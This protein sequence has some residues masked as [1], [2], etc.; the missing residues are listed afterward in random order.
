MFR[1]R[2]DSAYDNNR[3]DRA[4]YFYAQCGCNGPGLPGPP[5]LERSVDYQDF[6]SYLE[7]AANE[8]FSV[9]VE[10]PWRL[11]N[12]EVNA[13]TAGYAD[14]NAGF[15]VGLIAVPTEQYLTFQLRAYFPTGD[16]DRGLGTDHYTLEPAF[17]F[18]SRFGRAI[19]EGEFKDWI[20]IGGTDFAGNVL[21]Y[22][23]GLSYVVLG[24][25]GVTATP[26]GQTG[27]W[28]APVLEFVGWTVLDG[29]QTDGQTGA[30]LDASGDTIVNV[31]AGV[32]VGVGDYNSIYV[33]Y[34]R[35]LT[36][37]VWYRDLVRVEYRLAF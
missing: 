2:Y 6:R 36:G 30:I 13:N 9:F 28:A 16:A 22:G 4:E 35:A 18:F 1:F 5:L 8:T 25:P 20:P 12:P 23:L 17:L 15:K 10:A 14:M 32:R 29:K 21:Q 27:V 26:V 3:P 31:K 11:L 34:G 19:I 33:G 37:D 7:L 24:D